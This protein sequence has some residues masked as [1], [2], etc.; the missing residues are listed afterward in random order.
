MWGE[1]RV[2]APGLGHHFR[3]IEGGGQTLVEGRRPSGELAVIDQQLQA[4]EM[5]LEHHGQALGLEF[6]V[7]FRG[8]CRGLHSFSR[9]GSRE[10]T[11]LA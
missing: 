8:D 11:P 1:G 5:G 9:R 6:R 10:V 3:Q 7:G 2:V 4:P